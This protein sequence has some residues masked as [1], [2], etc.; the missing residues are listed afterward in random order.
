ML[1]SQSPEFFYLMLLPMGIL[2]W[3]A[4]IWAIAMFI[5]I[6]RDTYRDR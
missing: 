5:W 1:L 4:V 6:I 2:I 3:G